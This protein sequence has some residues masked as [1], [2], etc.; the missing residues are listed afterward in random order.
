[1]DYLTKWPEVFSVK[2]QTIA[3]MVTVL[4]EQIISKHGVPA[5]ILSDRGNAFCL[6]CLTRKHKLT[7][8]KIKLHLL[9]NW[10]TT[11]QAIIAKRF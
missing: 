2:D 4:L 5:E 1:M 7:G 8:F 11:K 10:H 3:T 6:S 9:E